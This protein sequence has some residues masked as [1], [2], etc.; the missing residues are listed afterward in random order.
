MRRLDDWPRVTFDAK[1]CW[2][3]PD[4]MREIQDNQLDLRFSGVTKAGRSD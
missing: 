4:R 2:P 1:S 3:A